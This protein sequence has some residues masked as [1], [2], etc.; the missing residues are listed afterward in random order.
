[1]K[2]AYCAG[3][4][5]QLGRSSGMIYLCDDCKRTVPTEIVPD[6]L[7]QTIVELRER[8]AFLERANASLSA[9]RRRVLDEFKRC[10]DLIPYED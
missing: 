2:Y 1:M 3:C 5:A 7:E 4:G 8:V 6:S 10:V 9:E